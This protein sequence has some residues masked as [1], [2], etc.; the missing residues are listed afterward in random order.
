MT[1]V[2]E[3]RLNRSWPKTS[4][5]SV[6]VVAAISGGADSVA[7]LRCMHSLRDAAQG[8]LVAAHFNHQLHDNSSSA[9]QF[10]EDLCAKL[11]IPC[12]VGVPREALTSQSGGSLEEAAR[13]ARYGFLVEI[14]KQVGARYI[15]TAH[16]ADD[17]AETILH[18]IVRG[19]GIRGLGGIPVSRVV[20][21][22][23]TLK[24]P[25]L[26]VQRAEIIEYLA[27]LRQPFHQDPTNSDELFTRN[28]IRHGLLP[29]LRQH[30]NSQVDESLRRLGSLAA[31]MSD[32]IESIAS[33]QFS[34]C[35]S[36]S[37]HK[38]AINLEVATSIP[39][40]VLRTIFRQIWRAQGWPECDMTFERWHELEA[41]VHSP[42]A[43]DA[44]MV[45]IF[46]S[47]IRVI[48]QGAELI[49]E[50]QGQPTCWP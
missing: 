49:I 2:L 31:E 18:R 46:P 19:T 5:Q 4:W 14:A 23:I 8:T 50:S 28:R 25:L 27:E 20:A 29:M 41:I 17:Q 43:P 40:L 10:V 15:A 22:N 48:R 16:T 9:A 26:D 32:F 47:S 12:E 38:I 33:E 6:P 1:R 13:I 3:V 44:A 36:L 34:R 11:Q 24:R 42:D 37:E 21:P 35:V 7:L 39:P 45:R 30:Y